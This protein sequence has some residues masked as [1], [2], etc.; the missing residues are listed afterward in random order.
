M[1]NGR[2]SY[3]SLLVSQSGTLKEGKFGAT[4]VSD[5][6]ISN[7]QTRHVSNTTINSWN[8]CLLL[9]LDDVEDIDDDEEEEEEVG[10]G[11]GGGALFVATIGLSDALL[12]R[13]VTCKKNLG[14]SFRLPLT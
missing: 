2:N 7:S 10:G 3:S 1:I 5:G 6:S 4:R 12:F 8:E 14:T 13:D 11:G 9:P